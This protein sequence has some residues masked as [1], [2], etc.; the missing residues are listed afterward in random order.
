MPPLEHKDLLEPAVLWSFLRTGREGEPIVAPPV[1]IPVRWEEGQKEIAD[2]NGTRWNVDVVMATNQNMLLGSI[3]WEG[4]L[5]AIP[6]NPTSGLY[7]I[8]IRERAEDIKYRVTRY[9]FGLR[10]YKNT[11]PKVLPS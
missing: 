5:S 2:A 8:V 1:Q 10:R 7:E 6:P 9:E 11:L 3:I 4:A